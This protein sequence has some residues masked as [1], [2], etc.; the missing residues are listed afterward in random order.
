VSVLLT[1]C[2]SCLTGLGRNADLG[3]Q[4]RHI[5]VEFALALSGPGWLDKLRA[6]AASAQAVRF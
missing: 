2:P 6:R 5:A 3:V 4:P 1:N